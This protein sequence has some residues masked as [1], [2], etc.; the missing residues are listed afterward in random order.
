MNTPTLLALLLVLPLL[1]VCGWESAMDR[2]LPA[3]LK[4]AT[5]EAPPDVWFTQKL[6]H[7]DPQDS[8][9]FQQRYMVNGSYFNPDK[10]V[11]F[12][13]LGGEGPANPMWLAA[14]TAIMLYAQ[15]QK[16]MVVQL[17]HRYY[18]KT[19]PVTNL[20]TDNLRFL[21][22]E[23]ALA[24]AAYFVPNLIKS[25][26][27]SA[28]TQ[29]VVFGGSYSGALAAWA[30]IKYPHIFVGAVATSSPVL[31]L[32]KFVQYQE[33]VI[34]SLQTTA[35]GQQCTANIAAG[36]V[37]I[38]QLLSSASGRAQLVKDFKIC[39]SD[40][41]SALDV[42]NFLASVAGNFDGVVQYNKDN[43][44]FEGAP[45]DT[46]TIDDLCALMTS[47]PSGY[48]GLL[49]VNNYMLN[50]SSENCFN[51]SYQGSIAELSGTSWDSPSA[52]GG[53][54]WTYQTC[55]E[56]AYFQSSETTQSYFGNFPVSLFA[57]QCQD[58]FGINATA[59][60]ADVAWTNEYYGGK[61]ISTSNIVFPNGSI[62]PWHILSVTDTVVASSPAIF[63]NGTAHCANMYPPSPSDL[64]ELS[65]ARTQILQAIGSWLA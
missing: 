18:G 2:G 23:Q 36:S 48:Q 57:Q 61:N 60:M 16:A 65:A 20:S 34:R 26:N 41:S 25:M 49:D 28:S 47:A 38:T 56:F 62:D 54:Q 24:D 5:S 50:Q 32:F 35:K 1:S 43:R 19:H 17:E 12:L 9:T 33:V 58:V 39:D 55:T 45:P 6:N 53:R 44:A 30:R 59:T 21:S 22:S 13:L 7:F 29:V 11:V 63:I 52:E 10:P 40:L 46:P 31:A 8:T 4:K 14:D 64:P 15:E 3:R 51:V 27:M 37:N 42:Q